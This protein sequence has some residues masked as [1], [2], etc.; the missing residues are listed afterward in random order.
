[1]RFPTEAALPKSGSWAWLTVSRGCQPA[2]KSSGDQNGPPMTGIG[3][4]NTPFLGLDV[5]EH[6]YHLKDR[7]RRSEYIASFYNVAD[8]VEVARRYAAARA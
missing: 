2:V 1:M 7:N 4:S 5:W 3:S 6:A 8:W